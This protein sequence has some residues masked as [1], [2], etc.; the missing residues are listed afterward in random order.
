MV[1]GLQQGFSFVMCLGLVFT[2][3]LGLGRVLSVGC[4]KNWLSGDS[5]TLP[6]VL[7]M[8]R[9]VLGPGSKVFHE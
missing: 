9:V 5:V 1:L 7:G 3:V 4:Q 8:R 6:W 2:H